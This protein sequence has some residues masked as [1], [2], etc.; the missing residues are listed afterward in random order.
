[1]AQINIQRILKILKPPYLKPG[2]KDI[3]LWRK[4]EQ[5]DKRVPARSWETLPSTQNS[6]NERES[7]LCQNKYVKSYLK[8]ESGTK[9]RDEPGI[10]PEN[11]Y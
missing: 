5:F 10:V 7:Y 3:I 11:S 6:S 8:A 4:N 2:M 9:K 1:M